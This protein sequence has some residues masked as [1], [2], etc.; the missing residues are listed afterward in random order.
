MRLDIEMT[1][2]G[3]ARSRER[4]KELIRQGLVTVDGR[5]VSKPSAEVS[6]TAEIQC[7]GGLSYVGRG[8]L[9][10]EKA[11]AAFEI[12]LNG[13]T[14]IDIGA[15]TGGFTDCMLQNGAAKVYAVDVGHDQLAEELRSDSRVVSMEGTDIRAV[16]PEALGGG[17]D[18]IGADVSFIS[19]EL[20][21][22]S[23]KNLL[24]AEGCACLLI[25]PQFEAGRE[26]VGKNGIVKDKKT[27]VRVIEKMIAAV[28]CNG[29][30]VGGLDFSPIRGG[31][32]NIEYLIFIKA[33]GADADISAE[34]TVGR[35]F[36]EL[37]G[38]KE[39]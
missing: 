19:L 10:L 12:D 32:G 9:K 13:K 27:H 33:Q 11:V 15:S 35:A 36:S 28:K 7:T 18:F 16:T 8:G 26:A 31:E 25:K 37:K 22:P 17:A 1:A 5:V 6:E 39:R 4:A 34:R 3:L 14:C 2:R 38:A 21:L 30:T 23:V 20:I 24:S 29:L